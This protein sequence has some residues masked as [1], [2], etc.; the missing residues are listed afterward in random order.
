MRTM[1]LRSLLVLAIAGGTI[2]SATHG[3]KQGARPAPDK[4]AEP[5]NVEKLNKKIDNFALRA[6][7]GK[8][9]SL[10]GLKGSKAVVVVFLSFECPVST[11]YSPIL[12]ELHKTYGPKGVT[13]LGVNSS[14]DVSAAELAKRAAEYKQ[15]GRASCRERV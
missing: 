3:E 2:P 15:I 9:V 14:E 10:A 6:T 12:A 1:L 5:V 11:S 13:F 4:V 8:V 7:D